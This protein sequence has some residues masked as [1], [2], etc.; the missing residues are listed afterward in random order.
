MKESKFGIIE[1]LFLNTD[2]YSTGSLLQSLCFPTMRG[3]NV[4]FASSLSVSAMTVRFLEVSAVTF[5]AFSQRLLSDCRMYLV[6]CEASLASKAIY[7]TF[8]TNSIKAAKLSTW[9][10]KKAQDK[11]NTS[12]GGR[13]MKGLLVNDHTSSTQSAL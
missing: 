12:S 11:R 6:C 8:T 9:L 3:N 7:D 13:K 10:S 5:L 4:I 1:D 2:A